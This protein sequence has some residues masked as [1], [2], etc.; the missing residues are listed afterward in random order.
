MFIIISC[1]NNGNDSR[2]FRDNEEENVMEEKS[3]Y[4]SIQEVTTVS[5]SVDFAEESNRF[6]N[7]VEILSAD[8][9]DQHFSQIVVSSTGEIIVPTIGGLM[10][11]NNGFGDE[12]SEP[13]FINVFS[14]VEEN[15]KKEILQETIQYLDSHRHYYEYNNTIANAQTS[16]EILEAINLQRYDRSTLIPIITE[17]YKG[18]GKYGIYYN[19]IYEYLNIADID[20]YSHELQLYFD[21]S[22]GSTQYGYFQISHMNSDYY[23]YDRMEPELDVTVYRNDLRDYSVR[24]PYDFHFD[25]TYNHRPYLGYSITRNNLLFSFS[26][27]I[28]PQD[29]LINL[30]LFEMNGDDGLDKIWSWKSQPGDY[31]DLIPLPQFISRRQVPYQFNHGDPFHPIIE[32][33]NGNILTCFSDSPTRQW[34][35]FNGEEFIDVN[36]PT[37]INSKLP[38]SFDYSTD[39]R[40]IFL[41]RN[42]DNALWR[43]EIVFD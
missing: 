36:G 4:D 39:K 3:R 37:V 16:N 33:N 15:E 28:E 21:G 10:Y 35:E 32:L 14:S 43:Y 42:E 23:I 7:G 13:V 30:E 34:V 5:A 41:F 40:F 22:M 25:G 31:D 26:Y 17:R 24:I 20:F 29:R 19:L 27:F 11:W 18:E 9:S 6:I 12:F 1:F 2:D 38:L 8:L